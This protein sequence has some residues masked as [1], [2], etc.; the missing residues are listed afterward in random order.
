MAFEHQRMLRDGASGV[1]VLV[2]PGETSLSD[3]LVLAVHTPA[4]IKA[5]ENRSEV[6]RRVLKELEVKGVSLIHPGFDVL[7]IRNGKIDRAIELKSSGVDARVQE[8]SWN[9]W[10]SSSSSP[11]RNMFYL[12]L[13]GNL[14]ADLPG[15]PYL[16]AIHDPFGNMP[17]EEI[18]HHQTRRVI[19]LQVREFPTAE[20]LDLMPKE[21]RDK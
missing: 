11:L 4:A 21:V 7:S 12:Y 6:V 10:K 3:D 14:R 5:A 15:V 17:G 13:V 9:E 19:Q 1:T 18:T 2:G 20:H 16:R 8:M